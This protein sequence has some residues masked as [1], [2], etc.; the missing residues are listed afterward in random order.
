ME[1]QLVGGVEQRTDLR[2]KQSITKRPSS[3]REHRDLVIRPGTVHQ[4][5][6]GKGEPRTRLEYDR[7]RTGGESSIG[8]SPLNHGVHLSLQV[9]AKLP[10][11]ARKVQLS[12]GQ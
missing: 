11:Q 9:G 5:S 6:A 7:L 10:E 3:S 8:E 12:V 2:N 4:P 1:E